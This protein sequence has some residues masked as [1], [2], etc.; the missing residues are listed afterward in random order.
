MPEVYAF[1]DISDNVEIATYVT[2]KGNVLPVEDSSFV[3]KYAGKYTITYYATDE[4]GN[5]T[6]AS[7]VV[8]V[9]E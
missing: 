2:Y 6:M 7:T 3:A 8:F 1:D 4:A 5:V 9:K